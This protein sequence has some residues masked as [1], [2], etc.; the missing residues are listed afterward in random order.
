M[1]SLYKNEYRI[2]KSVEI[3]IRKGLSL[4]K[5][6]KEE[7][8]QFRPWY[9]DTQKCHKETPCVAIL[10]KQNVFFFS[11][12]KSENR[13]EKQVLSE[14]GGWYQWEGGGCEEKV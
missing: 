11:F 4:R 5:K 9:L 10:N 3:N 7:M 13:R 6:K 14:W 12:T 2:F 1:Y 8:N